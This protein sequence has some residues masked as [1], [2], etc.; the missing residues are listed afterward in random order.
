MTFRKLAVLLVVAGVSPALAQISIPLPG[1]GGNIQIGPQD[2]QRDTRGYDNRAHGGG[3][4]IRILEAAYGRN[5]RAQMGG[6]NVINDIAQ[7]CQG[8]DYCQYYIDVRRLG[9]P[10]PGCPKEYMARFVC[11]DG[12]N[13]IWATARAE[14]NGQSVTLDCRRR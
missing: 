2:Q 8:R 13:E 11:R 9:D 4:S 5:C 7:A 12:G 3:S 14:A 10:A 6:G 1:T